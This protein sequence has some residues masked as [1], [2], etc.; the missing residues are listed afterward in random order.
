MPIFFSS[1]GGV[2]ACAGVLF[3]IYFKVDMVILY[4]IQR[5]RT[6]VS[7]KLQNFPIHRILGI[8]V[9]SHAILSSISLTHRS[10]VQMR[11]HHTMSK[12]PASDRFQIGLNYTTSR[13]GLRSVQILDGSR[14][15]FCTPLCESSRI[16]EIFMQMRTLHAKGPIHRPRIERARSVDGPLNTQK[17]NFSGRQRVF[18]V[19]MFHYHIFKADACH[20]M[21]AL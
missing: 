18:D 17:C 11:T 19:Y 9:F 21:G 2:N 1:A 12:P 16:T 5:R 10:F 8:L 20:H 3:H 13:G 6:L 15:L 14:Y 7:I 4:A